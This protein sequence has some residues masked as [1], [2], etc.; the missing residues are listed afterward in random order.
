VT[1][2]PHRADGSITVRHGSVRQS[3]APV[4]SHSQVGS[5]VRVGG[6]DQNA[7]AATGP[8]RL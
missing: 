4:A 7:S 5:R 2:A 8:R 3:R 1:Y 6:R